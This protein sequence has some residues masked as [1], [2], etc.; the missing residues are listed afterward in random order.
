MSQKWSISLKKPMEDR[1]RKKR[2]C[3]QNCLI[4]MQKF[5]SIVQSWLDNFG[6]SQQ[7]V[8]SDRLAWLGLVWPPSTPLHT[9]AVGEAHWS[10]LFAAA[11]KLNDIKTQPKI[12][13]V[14]CGCLDVDATLQSS[15]EKKTTM[16]TSNLPTFMH[17]SLVPSHCFPLLQHATLLFSLSLVL[18]ARVVC[19]HGVGKAAKS[20][21]VF[22]AVRRVASWPRERQ[23]LYISFLKAGTWHCSHPAIQPAN[24]NRPNKNAKNGKLN[25][26]VSF[27]WMRLGCCDDDD[28]GCGG[29]GLN[30][31]P[32]AKVV[33]H[34]QWTFFMYRYV[35][36]STADWMDLCYRLS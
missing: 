19:G 35:D 27:S 23:C 17:L 4:T 29:G 34:D 20:L 14:W 6:G 8:P 13:V 36:C 15:L 22:V 16:S 33:T 2:N 7:S 25:L 11:I 32:F 30:S 24:I 28:D 26:T 1:P 9:A 21:E 12:V 3:Q 18:G 10:L 5:N 31:V